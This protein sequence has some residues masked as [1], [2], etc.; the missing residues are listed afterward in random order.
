[1]NNTLIF[2]VGTTPACQFAAE[3][4]RNAGFPIT[5]HPAPEVTHLLLDVPSFRDDGRLRSGAAVESLLS[6]L[7]DTVTVIG[8]NLS[9]P[10]VQNKTKLDLLKDPHYLWENASITAHCALKIAAPLLDTTL[11]D[12]PALI[13]GWG[14]IGKCLA[15]LLR[16][17]DC[18]VTVAARKPTDRA[19]LQ[20]LGYSSISM[21]A[22]PQQLSNFRLMFNTA[23]ETV[24]TR[25]EL[26]R[27]ADCVKIDLASKR[28]LED[29]SVIWARGLPGIH[30]VKSSGSLIARRIL[31]SIKE[32]L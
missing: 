6:M 25:Q 28:G 18:P 29:D 32:A 31:Y 20:S 8:G 1:M 30:A 15:R 3:F 2:P 26:A 21:E 16:N 10:A 4:L 27:C 5:D 22:L 11:A 23:P 7:P 24:L 13:I 19:A 9:H 17:L 12:T 14:R